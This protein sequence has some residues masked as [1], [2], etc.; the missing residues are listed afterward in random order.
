MPTRVHIYHT[1]DRIGV[2]YKFT[3]LYIQISHSHTKYI[4]ARIILK[5]VKDGFLELPYDQ[6]G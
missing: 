2:F 1:F 6:T 3:Y 5:P 4:V